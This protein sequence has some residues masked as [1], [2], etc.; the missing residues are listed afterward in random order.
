M[1]YRRNEDKLGPWPDRPLYN[2]DW[3]AIFSNEDTTEPLTL[4]QVKD[5]LRISGTDFDSE[6]TALIK[7]CRSEIERECKISLIQRTVKVRVKYEVGHSGYPIPWGPVITMTQATDQD[8]T[9]IS[10]D[11]YELKDGKHGKILLTHYADITFEFD[12][13]FAT[14]NDIPVEYLR[15]LEERIA[16]RFANKGDQSIRKPGVTWLY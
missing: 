15:L 12:A 9:V 2:N 11:G 7:R 5:Y 4:T 13:G 6:L 1:N 10:S 14:V 16:Y 3:D 8:G